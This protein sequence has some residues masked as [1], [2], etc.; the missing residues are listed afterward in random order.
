M[1]DTTSPSTWSPDVGEDGV[2]VA[3][4]RIVLERGHAGDGGEGSAS[5]AADLAITQRVGRVLVL[6]L[7]FHLVGRAQIIFFSVLE[8]EHAWEFWRSLLT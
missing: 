7:P 8:G 6:P 4:P 2:A 3:A 1:S 5:C